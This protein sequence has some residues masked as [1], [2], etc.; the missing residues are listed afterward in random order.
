VD[1]S[2]RPKAPRGGI[3]GGG[4]PLPP[5]KG[6]GE[7]A[8]PL[9]QFFLLFDL[10]MEDFA[11]VFKLDL[12]DK[13]R[14]QLQEEETIASASYWLRLWSQLSACITQCQIWQSKP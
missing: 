3:R 4:V 9:S 5:E 13:T 8:R 12:M 14:T 7:G 6:S 10:K 11:A 1:R 2:S